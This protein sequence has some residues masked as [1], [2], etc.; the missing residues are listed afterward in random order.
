M[1]RDDKRTNAPSAASAVARYRI[2][3]HHDGTAWIAEVPELP[4]CRATG[5]DQAA[6]L[7]AAQAAIVQWL[8]R[9]RTDAPLP[10]LQSP[11]AL[12]RSI[13]D[14][15]A[16]SQAGATLGSRMSPA[17]R[18]LVSK[19]GKMSNRE[20]AGRI[21]LTGRDAPTMLSAAASG[22]GT[23]KARCAIAL[24]LDELPS[25][26]WPDRLPGI[27]HDDDAMYTELRALRDGEIGARETPVRTP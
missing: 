8:R 20:L 3:L 27:C 21:G 24:A 15:L 26:L 14:R 25:H 5:D 1:H 13:R 2:L 11:V 4:G 9:L 17:K 12:G 6:A 7:R 23:R 16:A 19:F 18:L 22:K 10:A